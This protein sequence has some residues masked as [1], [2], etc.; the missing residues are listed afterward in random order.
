MIHPDAR[1]AFREFL[2][3]AG[4]LCVVHE[5]TT[6][7]RAERTLRD[8]ERRYRA[9]VGA[10]EEGVMVHDAAAA[11]VMAHPAAER[12]LGLSL[13]QMRGLDSFDLRWRAVIRTGQP[14]SD[15]VFGI[16]RSDGTL[17]WVRPTPCR[18]RASPGPAARPAS[19]ARS[20]T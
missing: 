13:D 8:S 20:S 19:S 14:V 12:I 6:S 7:V 16:H 2:R 5:E 17:V 11:I 3:V 9:V 15:V 4:V 10:L 18:C 1:P